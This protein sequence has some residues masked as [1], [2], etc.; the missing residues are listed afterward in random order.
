VKRATEANKSKAKAKAKTAA[1]AAPVTFSLDTPAGE[2]KDMSAP[3]LD[4]YHPTAVEHSW[5]AWWSA[6][7]FYTA[8]P[9]T[10]EAAGEAGRFVM[11]IPPPNVTGSLH[12]GH[13]LTCSI[14]DALC[15]WHRMHGRPV[16]WLPGTDHA[17]IATQTVVERRLHKEKGITRHDL[18]RETFLK[19]VW[20]WKESYGGRIVSQLK[21]LG[22][23]VDWT[24]ERFTMDEG[25]SK[26]V[27]EAFCR[28]NEKGLI[29]RDTRLV[30]WCCALRSAISDIEV[31]YMELEKPESIE[32]P[33]HDPSKKYEFG[34]IMSFAYVVE[35]SDEKL[36][37]ATTR[38]E[39]MLGDVA[40]AVHP[41]DPRYKHLHGKNVVHPFCDRVIPIICDSELVDMS[42]GTGAVKITPAHDPNDFLC[43]RRHGLP[44]I[45]IFDDEGLV[46]A[47]GGEFAG[48][49]RFDARIA[50]RAA[51]EQRGLFEGVAPNK[52][53]IGRCSRTGDIIE[54]M[55]KPQW[56]V[57][58]KDMA[59]RAVKAVRDGDLRIEPKM[60]EVTWFRWLE[61]PKD[62]CISRQLWWGHRIPAY[63][64][65]IAG[66]ERA[67]EVDRDYWVVA[68]SPEAAAAK[69]AARF[70]VP[71]EDI[72]LDQDEDV[73]DT[74]FSSGLFPFSTFGWPEETADLKAFYP[75][76]LLETGHDILFF[77]VARMV[78]MGL[79]L[80]DQ[81]PF[82]TV[83]LHAMV[84]DKYGRKMSKT[85]GNVIDPLEV[86][87]GCPL[88]VL[89]SKLESGNLPA[90][91]IELAKRGQ[92]AEFPDGIPECGSDAL[93]FGLL[94]YTLQGRDINLNISLVV[95]YRQ[96]CN[97]LWNACRFALLNFEGYTHDTPAETV[98]GA[99]ARDCA[100][101]GGTTLGDSLSGAA[102]AS[103]S[104]GEESIADLTGMPLTV[105]A[106]S[107]EDVTITL[108]PRDRWILS[109]L[110]TA[111]RE[112][113]SA[114]RR[115]AFAVA[116]ST[117]HKFWLEDLCDK[118]LE[119]SKPVFRGDDE[120]AKKAARWTLYTCLD[121]GLRLLHP[122]MPFVTEELWH[123][124]PGRGA[125][126]A[127]GVADPASIMIAPWPLAV[128]GM[129]NPEL[130]AGFSRLMGM[131]RAVRVIRA[132]AQLPHSKS[133]PIFLSVA[134]EAARAVAE[135]FSDDLCALGAGSS[136]TIQPAEEA[137]FPAGC[138]MEVAD[139]AI[140]A[141]VQLRG[142]I[143]ADA[144][145]AR[146]SK[147]LPKKDSQLAALNARMAADS[148]EKVPEEIKAKV[149]AD[150]QRLSD[151]VAA[152]HQ[153]IKAMEALKE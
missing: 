104:S 4:S 126:W 135:A 69:A 30:N 92:T 21:R 94:A 25:L 53:S 78:M 64:V 5:D 125:P 13:A 58:C 105:A 19:H 147:Q 33:G 99:L 66:K 90:K 55:L 60:H 3:M 111:C 54:P 46:N 142:L 79:E 67:D 52:M 117:V 141:A 62:W 63:F 12:L 71:V 149:T 81:L 148:W 36:I 136:L 43:G 91:E 73:L 32:V 100:A 120:A 97:K 72:T 27:T 130:E 56:W 83:Y 143:D 131:V 132:Q 35:G 146:L 128:E 61:S 44:E 11:V 113:E 68:R 41:D 134:D 8:E 150:T 114:F 76:S 26:A 85:L 108:A 106:P 145:I 140:T 129:D 88:S 37:V 70:G 59:A 107:P 51:L 75:N 103:S 9:A 28:M 82:R 109:R 24:R 1:S 20:E 48:M 18:G 50:V 96:F 86:I 151:E 118:Y 65:T 95:A 17:G 84:R 42:F 112:T 115:F 74:W 93:R 39:T 98:L 89:H 122:M 119:L 22:V 7:G 144:E 29:Y 87:D 16:M 123:R 127:P 38:L 23:S 124:L 10:A 102:A 101:N 133:A 31:D 116:C 110:N 45:T 49:R 2:K 80:T 34:T 14:E 57:D 152:I 153:A 77:W 138:A 121:R 137:S 15:R 47:N 6:Q 40:V 139:E